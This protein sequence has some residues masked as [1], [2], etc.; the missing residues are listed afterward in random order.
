MVVDVADR[1]LVQRGIFAG[2]SALVNNDLYT[3]VVSGIARRERTSVRMDTHA[4]I[5]TNTY[6][7]RFAASYWQRHT[8]LVEIKVSVRYASEARSRISVQASDIAGHIRTIATSDVHGTGEEQWTLKLDKFVDGGAMWIKAEALAGPLVIDEISWWTEVPEVIHPAAIAICT[9]NRADDCV[10]TVAAL[11]S[12]TQ[13]LDRIESIYVVD[14]GTDLVSSR[15][16]FSEVTERLGQKVRYLRQPNLGGAG[17]FSRGMLEITSSVSAIAPNVILMDDDI[18]CEPETVLRLNAFANLAATPVL[19]GAQMLYLFNP[20]YLLVSAEMDNL[21]TLQSGQ[22]VPGS[23]QNTSMVK[24]KQERRV[25]AAYNAWWTCLIPAAVIAD[26][27]LPLP[28]FFQWDDIEF[29]I[30]AREYGYPTVTLPNAAVWHADFYWKDRDDFSKYFITRN[31]LITAAL[32]SD[33][34]AHS[35]SKE[36]FREILHYLV[37]M[38]YGLALTMIRGVEDFLKGPEVLHDGGQQAMAAIR[39][40]RKP[41]LETVRHPAHDIPNIRSVD[42]VTYRAAPTP[43]RPDLILV[44][45]IIDRL[46]GNLIGGIAYIPLEDAH[47][48]H[49]SRFNHAVVADASQGGVRVRKRDAKAAKQLLRRALRAFSQFRKQAPTVQQQ[50]KDAYPDLTGKENWTRLYGS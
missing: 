30:R 17:G 48:Y 50:F 32:H 3:T 15:K 43:S 5:S 10:T 8:A 33:F 36:M 22:P 34:D 24:K 27:G 1:Y 37:S 13:V 4:V 28:Y 40:E 9:F 25:D 44:K 26:I 41:F 47:W 20:D 42:L 6:F 35:L 38:Q 16:V 11:A 19:V 7:G 29:G 12:D 14:Q 23:L 39:E 31:S 21:A 49:I 46:R 18:L 2:P 45:R